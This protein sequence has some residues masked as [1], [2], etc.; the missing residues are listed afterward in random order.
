MVKKLTTIVTKYLKWFPVKG[1]VSLYYTPNAIINRMLIYYENH[2]QIPFGAYVQ[3]YDEPQPS[4]TQ[5]G[6]SI[7]TIYL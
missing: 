7:D 4:N 1:R 5:I 2:R 6:R 3:V